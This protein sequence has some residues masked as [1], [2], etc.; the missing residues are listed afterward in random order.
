[1]AA[2]IAGPL[3]ASFVSCYDGDT[4]RVDIEVW[5]DLAVHAQVRLR[6]VDAPEINGKCAAEKMLAVTARD[7]LIGILNSSSKIQISDIEYDKYAGRV[8]ANVM[9]DGQSAA[10]LIIAE[11]L[12]RPYTGGTREGWC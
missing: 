3:L 5:L 10:E 2:W 12:G 9:V 8:V 4:C 6:G 7:F 1:V 11:G